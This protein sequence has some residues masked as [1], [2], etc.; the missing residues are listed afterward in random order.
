MSV[1]SPPPDSFV[2]DDKRIEAIEAPEKRELAL[3][4]WLST[5]EKD[6]QKTKDPIK[7]HQAALEKL[8]L[9]FL[10]SQT[11]RPSRPIY[12]LIAR[13]FVALYSKGDPRTLFDTIV[14]AQNALGAKKLDDLAIKLALVHCLGVLTEAHG[15]KVMSLFGETASIYI[16]ILKN[17]RDTDVP[18]RFETLQ[19]ASRALTGAGKA[20]NDS[21]IKDLARF[22]KNGIS[23]KLPIIRQAA[24]ELYEAL[25]KHT[26]QLPPLNMAEYET[27]VASFLKPLEGSN[28]FARRAF[29]NLIASLLSIAQIP[30]HLAKV[31]PKRTNAKTDPNNASNAAEKT[32]LSEEEIFLLISNQFIKATSRESRIG[33]MEAAA[34]FL[35][36]SGPRFVEANYPV[37]LKS[38]VELAASPKAASTRS[39]A[40]FVR[41]SC[42]FLL[43]EVAGKMLTETGQTNG[44][45]EIISSYVRRW[46]AVLAIDIAPSEHALAFVLGEL[47]ALFGDLGPAANDCQEG[48]MDALLALLAHP[49]VPVKISLAWVFRSFCLALPEYLSPVLNRLVGLF[50]KDLGL[51]T[52]DRPDMIDKII[53]YANVLSAVIGVLP[54]RVLY[55]SYEDAA[56]IFGLST[57]LLKSA[58]SIRDS[59][60]AACQ[61]QA[62]WTLI[63]A[64]MSLGPNF[65]KVHISQLLLIWKNVF[66]KSQPKDITAIRTE[67]DWNLQ[68]VSRE[69]AL[70]ALYSFLVYNAKELATSDVAKRIVVCLNNTL[71]FL[72]TIPATYGAPQD[73]QNATVVQA[74]LYERECQLRKRLFNCYRAF[75]APSI[76]ETTF[77]Q[78]VKAAVDVFALDPEKPDRFPSAPN[79]QAKDG[80]VV[81]ESVLPTS[82][83]SGFTVDVAADSEA[84]D[85]GISKVLA[86]DTDVQ[87]L[88][89][90]IQRRVFGAL[91]ND[92]HEL[93]LVTSLARSSENG[94]ESAFAEL[95]VP[96]P[97][98]RPAGVAAVDAAIELFSMLLPLQN[99]QSQE[100]F[101]E[102]L[103]KAATLQNG[104]LTPLR[105]SATQI[106]VLTAAMGLL[107]YAMV[108]RGQ[109]GSGKVAVVIRDLVDPLLK[110]PEASI[111][112]MASEIFG[113][114]ARVVGTAAFVNPLI[115]NLVDQVVANRDPESRAG[116]ALALGTIHSYVGG[117][118]ASAHLKTV[119]GILHSLASDPHPLVHTWALHAL[120]L[121]IE[122]AGLMYGP[123]VNSTLALVAKLYMSESHEPSAPAANIPGADSNADVYPAFGRILHALVGVIGP[124]LQASPSLRDIC[125]SLYEQ[126]KNDKDPFVVVEAIRC[127]QHFILFA[128]RFVD[129]ELLIPF[130]QLQLTDD[131]RTQ[132]YLIRKASVT[133]LYQLTQRDPET[134]LSATTNNQL[135][136]QL[137]ALLDVE[138]D[139][140]VRAEIKDILTALLR[141]TG[142][143][144]PSRW[145]DLCKNILSKTATPI[146]SSAGNGSS[147]P[148]SGAATGGHDLVAGSVAAGAG[149]SSAL[150]SAAG[151]IRS[152]RGVAGN[153]DDDDEMM[154]MDG[155]GDGAG[156]AG[157]RSTPSPQKSGNG[158]ASAS[159]TANSTALG[160]NGSSSGAVVH[161]VP[162]WRTQIFALVC[163][164]N[165]LNV[166]LATG[167]QEHLDMAVARAKRATL[168]SEGKP[169]DFLVFRLIDLIRMA[170]NS[171][172]A[173]VND[174]RLGGLYL[175]RDVLE[176]YAHV[177]DPDFDGHPLLEQYQAQIIAALAPAFS[178][179]S[180]PD[181]VST[182]CSVCA[183]FIGIS[184]DVAAMG[185]PLKLL[186]GLL[187][188]LSD[189]SHVNSLPSPNAFVMLKLAVLKAW[190]DLHS[191]AAKLPD[192][193][194]A[195]APQLDLLA[196]LWMSVLQDYAKLTV[197][198]DI[199][200]SP[201]ASDMSPGINLYMSATREVTLPFYRGAWIRI[202]RSF[203]DLIE[204]QSPST[205]KLFK[206][207]QAGQ[208]DRA[209]PRA[210]T[211]FMLFGLCI[212]A[213]SAAH[214]GPG[215]ASNGQSIHRM[216]GVDSALASSSASPD[217]EHVAVCLDSIRKMLRPHLLG[218]DFL[219]KP[220]FL[221]LLS[222]YDR[223]IQ[224]QDTPIQ[225]L[226]V[227]TLH[228][229]V[230]DY[231]ASYFAPTDGPHPLAFGSQDS[232][233]G[234]EP[235][236][237]TAEGTV[238]QDEVYRL[239][240]ALF[241]V[242]AIHIPG[243]S[244]SPSA[245][246]LSN[247]Q[248]T[249]D[250]VHLLLKAFETL[251][252]LANS[253][254][255]AQPDR[256]AVIGIGLCIVGVIA[257]VP[258]FASEV[259]PR[260]AVHLKQLLDAL[261][262][263]TSSA[264]AS[265]DSV[266]L[267][268]SMCS[269][270]A[271]LLDVVSDQLTDLLE[272]QQPQQAG[273]PIEL[274][275][276]KNAFLG[277]VLIVTSRPALSHH[278]SNQERIA[279]IVKAMLESPNVQLSIL[280]TQYARTL[281]LLSCRADAAE[282]QIGATYLRALLPILSVHIQ[283]LG[284]EVAAGLNADLLSALEESLK[285]LVLLV[286][287]A[288]GERQ[289]LGSL[290]VLVP[291]FLASMTD[292]SN[293][294]AIEFRSSA[295]KSIHLFATQALLQ[296]AS[297]Q[298]QH[299]KAVLQSLSEAQKGKL[300]RAFKSLVAAQS[301]A[302]VQVTDATNGLGSGL[303]PTSGAAAASAPK[304]QLK[305]FAAF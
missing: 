89:D 129:V 200:G 65:V 242:F 171:S 12:Q 217:A 175:L 212:E 301:A 105:R 113:R 104:K 118:A 15:S 234:G 174:L 251:V 181:I 82:L 225:L 257:R 1:V 237:S 263:D 90:L 151:G 7:P 46:P 182:A 41:E 205:A 81:I 33:I 268:N 201:Y 67:L 133:C 34:A 127:I 224:T 190:A 45:K 219:P 8:L 215:P 186:T 214:T 231:G 303:E 183:F 143:N 223:L 141:H 147:G 130:L 185:R 172:T 87:G 14:A 176:K 76:F 244:S 99:A 73:Q 266:T 270:V 199:S 189:E 284:T 126:L 100:T 55:S 248:M 228:Q 140:M 278:P 164:R 194:H 5:L 51:L 188:Q 35:R 42:S 88:E 123:F 71:H 91:E 260:V 289:R 58:G 283:R 287:G 77:T 79:A 17:A 78:L 2:F 109:L 226:I 227:E 16:K 288:Q 144:K 249:N 285:S 292:V 149:N 146:P 56:T 207:A 203:A 36:Q 114:L 111:R 69:S 75:N 296:L 43:R 10:S 83:V 192:L 85:R 25:Y 254:S 54:L 122:S 276:L 40:V 220:V 208:D 293:L 72:T 128:R 63:G 274:T 59:R 108:K 125:F 210:K 245:T 27:L 158:S 187:E 258:K 18:I 62:A 159:A 246:V 221:E 52:A 50:Q 44:V 272:A 177:P 19:A 196:K 152:T 290:A 197:D 179:E 241:D 261:R 28:Y 121:T 275:Q 11:V 68:L 286:A 173:N 93:Y 273:L 256:V 23:D 30:G 299:F 253:A 48:V 145:L 302:G 297:Q 86:R 106:N 4:Q 107:K 138:M 139:V 9:K 193:Q 95:T 259:M 115:Q 168:T 97:S 3:F 74:R 282:A 142:P 136:E 137:F 178:K 180:S 24:A 191:H 103:F 305:N 206:D 117:M 264:G 66:P 150:A 291:L 61:T 279:E 29:A 240:R 110:S 209:G 198:A 222:V 163:L 155:D 96:K 154:G 300:E 116:S 232:V 165:L 238:V 213:I 281:V 37:I 132:V 298:Q 21:T 166:V 255:V 156:D 84:E 250:T 13:L 204:K 153:D 64:L 31:S 295:A 211:F 294:S 229:I 70:A 26:S 47:A 252:L 98:P 102:H 124:E 243:I 131:Y 49:S 160:S 6:L 265:R 262:L 134:V 32:I 304:I 22:A 60:I 277:I 233:T 38:L 57:Q 202:L 157:F 267:A 112:C 280:G 39:E 170:F 92:P 94:L 53:G 101:V 167:H 216:A 169:A 119:V 239:L 247:R 120:W 135:E 235:A 148:T 161:L 184:D 218:T 271:S 230:Q 80:V 162:R 269:A 236:S 20:A 195:I